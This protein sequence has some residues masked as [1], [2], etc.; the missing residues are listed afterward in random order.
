MTGFVEENK[1]NIQ[2]FQGR[3]TWLNEY[4]VLYGRATL[5]WPLSCA[6]EQGTHESWEQQ[7]ALGSNS[8]LYL[9]GT[10]FQS[11]PRKRLSWIGIL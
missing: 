6:K 11:L 9:G 5:R 8:Y 1:V 2:K 3:L 10:R 4:R 7:V